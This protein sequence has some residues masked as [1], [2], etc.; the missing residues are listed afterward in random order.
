MS[1]QKVPDQEHEVP[2]QPPEN[3]ANVSKNA[4]ISLIANAI[5]LAS[6]LLVAPLAL[7]FGGVSLEVWG[8]WSLCWIMIAFFGMGAFGISNT[9]IRYVS[10]FN[11]RK[12]IDAMNR[13]ISTGLALTI[14]L[15]L[16]IL[17][18]LAFGM[19]I[20]MD[21]FNIEA[22]LRELAFVLFFGTSAVF[23]LDLSVGA[24]AYVLMG[25]QRFVEERL[26]WLIAISIEFLLIV[27]LLFAGMGIYGLLIA[28]AV[29]YLLSISV[30]AILCYRRIEGLSPGLKY[31]DRKYFGH[32]LKFGGTVQLTGLLAMLQES[33]ER[34]MAGKLIGT[35]AVGL[36]DLGQ[37]FPKM[38]TSVPTAINTT[39][40][41]AASH[42]HELKREQEL[43]DL[44]INGV[45]YLNMMNGVMLGYMFWFADPVI[46]AW[47]G[48]GSEFDRAVFLMMLFAIPYQC[49]YPDGDRWRHLPRYWHSLPR[50]VLLLCSTL[51]RGRL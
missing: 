39:I 13:L 12:D 22:D 45:R 28:F 20:I 18:G 14:S 46:R 5:Y 7:N 40:F 21:Q 50:N 42:L 49:P 43:R 3:E 47:L 35:V 25:L 26:V 48:P 16:I 15:A 33:V 51:V 44:Y 4:T 31:V 27:I 6:R 23:L 9:Y 2:E 34:L 17:L 38:A 1:E 30:Y 37:K 11:V 29:R 24:F 36:F 32:F 41:A 10:I 8:I 19:D